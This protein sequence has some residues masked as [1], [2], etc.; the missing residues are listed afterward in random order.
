M[1]SYIDTSDVRRKRRKIS[2][3]KNHNFLLGQIMSWITKVKMIMK[4][5]YKINAI[6]I[7]SVLLPM[8]LIGIVQLKNFVVTHWRLRKT[9]QAWE[10]EDTHTAMPGWLRECRIPC[11]GGWWGVLWLMIMNNKHL[12]C[13]KE[14]IWKVCQ[15]H[16]AFT[17]RVLALLL[18]LSLALHVGIL[19]F[20]VWWKWTV[21][22]KNYE[23]K[24][25][26]TYKKPP[27]KKLKNKWKKYSFK[28][29]VRNLK[30]FPLKRKLKNYPFK[31]KWKNLRN[32][33]HTKRAR[34]HERSI[35]SLIMKDLQTYMTK[36]RRKTNIYVLKITVK[37]IVQVFLLMTKKT[38][39]KKLGLGKPQRRSINQ[40]ENNKISQQ[41]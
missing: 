30:K 1:L 36:N 29:K 37:E 2:V 18:C 27:L 19:V 14:Q 39:R 17:R 32:T 24:P 12:D 41:I 23:V 26:S 34:K 22:A 13:L 35:Q 40:K 6:L 3:M 7:L 11:G 20:L 5:S 10:A 33:I 15:E 8:A 38:I 9:L 28:R 16:E 21:Q 25:K 4:C 31:R